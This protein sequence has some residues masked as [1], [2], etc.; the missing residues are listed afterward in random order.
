M[1]V[2]ALLEEA[3][4]HGVVVQVD[5]VQRRPLVARVRQRAAVV[6]QRDPLRLLAEVLGHVVPDHLGMRVLFSIYV[7]GEPV[8]T[9]HGEVEGVLFDAM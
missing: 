1:G 2:V 4:H 7:L 3:P 6:K 8:G 9:A 5:V